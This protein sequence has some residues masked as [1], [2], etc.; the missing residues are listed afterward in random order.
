[1]SLLW[2]GP[3]SMIKIFTLGFS[4]R[5]PATVLPPVPLFGVLRFVFWDVMRDAYPP[6]TMKS[7]WLSVG[8]SI[9][10][11]GFKVS[12]LIWLVESVW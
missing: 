6:T 11:L 1:M 12:F 9:L 10:I 5:R 2:P 4:A 8:M 7:K 3:A